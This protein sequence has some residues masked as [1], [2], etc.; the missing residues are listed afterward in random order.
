MSIL[1][2]D[3]V[4]S[5][6]QLRR[7]CYVRIRVFPEWIPLRD[8]SNN[9]IEGVGE[10]ACGCVMGVLYTIY[11]LTHTHTHIHTSILNRDNFV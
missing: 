2:G 11:P 1:I 3:I 4:K 8:S 9:T 10:C 7:I 6:Q 5:Q